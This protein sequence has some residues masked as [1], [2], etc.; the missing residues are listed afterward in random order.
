M[1]MVFTR[2]GL[3][4]PTGPGVGRE[5]DVRRLD[6]T[7]GDFEVIAAAVR[8]AQERGEIRRGVDPHQVAEIYVAV[9]YVTTRLWLT[10]YWGGEGALEERMLGALDVLMSGLRPRDP[11]EDG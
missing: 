10:G 6:R 7:R 8:G 2:S 1:E 3:F 4:F 5:D 9:F 11:K